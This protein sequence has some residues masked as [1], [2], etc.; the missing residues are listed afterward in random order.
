[1]PAYIAKTM[2]RAAHVRNAAARYTYDPSWRIKSMKIIAITALAAVALAGPAL[3]VRSDKPTDCGNK[4]NSYV[5]RH[6][7]HHVYGTPI[8]APIVGHAKISHRKY[9]LKKQS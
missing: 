8:Q 6:S 2:P 7:K 9:A 3:S 1:M 5:P 4:P